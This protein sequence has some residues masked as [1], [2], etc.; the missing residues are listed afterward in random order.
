MR[1]SILLFLAVAMIFP[2]FG[3]SYKGTFSNLSSYDQDGN[4]VTSDIF[5]DYD[6][7]MINIF[8]TWC[9]P[10]LSEMRDIKKLSRTLPENSNL[11]LV[12][13]DGYDNPEDFDFI[14]KY[15][16]L[17][18]PVLKM[19]GKEILSHYNLVAFP[20]NIFVDREGNIIGVSTGAGNYRKFLVEIKT[21]LEKSR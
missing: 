9:N 11:I 19:T 8:A 10:C 6:V 15:F 3:A 18:F 13:P 7:T 12:C 14:V 2:A 20:T 4:L 21:M 1:K 17:D 16:D 5:K